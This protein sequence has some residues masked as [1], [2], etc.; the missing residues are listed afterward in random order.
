DLERP[1]SWTFG[2][3]RASQ[4]KSGPTK[5]MPQIGRLHLWQPF[6]AF[7]RSKLKVIRDLVRKFTL[8]VLGAVAE[9]AQDWQH[10]FVVFWNS[11]PYG[12]SISSGGS[13]AMRFCVS[14]LTVITLPIS[15]TM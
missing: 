10:H 11:H 12:L 7:L 1:S 15:F 8:R 4:T 13:C 6:R 9:N 2:Q 14:K 5:S 3:A